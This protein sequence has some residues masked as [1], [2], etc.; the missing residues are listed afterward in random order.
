MSRNE[1]GAWAWSAAIL[2]SQYTSVAGA[3]GSADAGDGGDTDEDYKAL[4]L[5]LQLRL[6]PDPQIAGRGMPPATPEALRNHLVP[7]SPVSRLRK[8]VQAA[9]FVKISTKVAARMGNSAKRI[10][11]SSTVAILWATKVGSAE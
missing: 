9:L 1:T 7:L 11:P 2:S 3:S 4:C 10:R 6:E 8:L 5:R